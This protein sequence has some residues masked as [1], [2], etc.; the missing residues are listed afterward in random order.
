MCVTLTYIALQVLSER[1]KVIARL[2][3]V[4]GARSRVCSE[5][6]EDDDEEGFSIPLTS[7]KSNDSD[8]PKQIDARSSVANKVSIDNEQSSGSDS[9]D[10]GKPHS[11]DGQLSPDEAPEQPGSKE[12]TPVR[13]VKSRLAFDHPGPALASLTD[14]QSQREQ[15]KAAQLAKKSLESMS[16]REKAKLLVAKRKKHIAKAAKI[17]TTKSESR[18]KKQPPAEEKRQLV[19]QI[20]DRQKAQN[21]EIVDE[22]EE[23]EEEYIIEE[24]C[25][26]A[27]FYGA[28][29][30]DH[31]N[32]SKTKDTNIT[33]SSG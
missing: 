6:S 18:T 10:D 17:K 28:F 12:P 2:Q 33:L 9:E 11:A 31:L 20:E 16:A 25:S 32:Y 19:Q 22:H 30:F 14:S 1:F 13:R 26:Q 24:V 7:V 8:K 4:F 21:T 29:A 23:V 3:A 27:N 15:R 5:S